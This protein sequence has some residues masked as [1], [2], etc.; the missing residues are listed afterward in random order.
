MTGTTDLTTPPDRR[1]R[2]RR[3]PAT[4]GLSTPHAGDPFDGAAP[5]EPPRACDGGRVAHRRVRQPS[6][7]ST[8]AAF[9]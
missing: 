6:G 9:R 5:A 4:R 1:P 7:A 3:R 8:R 2:A